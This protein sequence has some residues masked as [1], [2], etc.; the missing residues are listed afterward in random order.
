MIRAGD[1]EA[2]QGHPAWHWMVLLS[3]LLHLAGAVAVVVVEKHVPRRSLESSVISVRLVG[4]VPGP[5]MVQSPASSGQSTPAQSKPAQ[6][7]EPTPS[8]IPV[9]VPQAE[10][11]AV[12]IQPTEVKV[13]K[14]SQPAQDIEA[15]KES[16]PK[17]P[18][19]AKGNAPSGS[20]VGPKVA[21]AQPG[22][23][24]GG[25]LTPEEAR[26]L[27][28]LQDRIEE[29]WRAYV[30]AEEAGVLGEVRIQIAGD[31]RIKEFVFVKGSGKSHVDSSIVSAL[32][33]VKLPPPP[34]SIADRPLVLRFWPSG[35]KSP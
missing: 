4:A 17:A 33:K 7:Q 23:G 27:Q 34:P 12:S 25:R 6:K 22:A 10:R 18:Q 28:M 2:S 11:K 26:Y 1:W 30:P 3:L 9:P 21:A 14:R 35:P 8:K 19:G 32:T 15:P 16:L 24:G 5:A 31:G 29:S 13:P 20:D